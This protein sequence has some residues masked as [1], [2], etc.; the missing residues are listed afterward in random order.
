MPSSVSNLGEVGVPELLDD[1]NTGTLSGWRSGRK[2]QRELTVLA[3]ARWDPV[4]ASVV[5]GAIS[6]LRKAH[7]EEQGS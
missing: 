2:F 4:L 6:V 3:A 7:C 1:W 5:L